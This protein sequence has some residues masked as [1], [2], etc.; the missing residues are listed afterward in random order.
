MEGKFLIGGVLLVIGVIG[1]LLSLKIIF[2]TRASKLYLWMTFQAIS[3][4]YQIYFVY[5]I[6]TNIEMYVIS[7]NVVLLFA[8]IDVAATGLIFV[9]VVND[10]HSNKPTMTP[11]PL[12]LDNATM[13]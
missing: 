4:A 12:G 11:E 1:I 3:I 5:F 13:I 10:Q 6:F 9:S 8:V 2:G 7:R